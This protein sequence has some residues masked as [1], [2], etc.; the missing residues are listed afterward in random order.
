MSLL[1]VLIVKNSHILA[2]TYFIF[3][4]KHRVLNLKG[5]QYQ[6]WTSLK[7]SGKFLSSEANFNIF[8]HV[9]CSNFRLKLCQGSL[10]YKN[11]QKNQIWGGLG[12]VRST[13]LFT[14]TTIHKILQTNSSF[15]VKQCSTG[16]VKFLFFSGYLLILT[17][18]SFWRKTG[19]K[20][21]IVLNFRIFLIFSN[22]LR[23]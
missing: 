17:K 4:K 3:L 8:S 9:S 10:R 6:I 23:S 18:F 7:R 20:A 13:K 12:R 11:C 16:K 1:T 22:F 19:H 5:F 2:G 21:I 14:E 15:Y